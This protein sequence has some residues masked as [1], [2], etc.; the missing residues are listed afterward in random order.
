MAWFAK[1]AQP[2]DPSPGNLRML[3]LPDLSVLYWDPF[4]VATQSDSQDPITGPDDRCLPATCT[5]VTGAR[6]GAIQC[7]PGTP[8]NANIDRSP[9]LHQ[10]RSLRHRKRQVRGNEQRQRQDWGGVG[11]GGFRLLE[12]PRS[13]LFDQGTETCLCATNGPSAAISNRNSVGR[14]LPVGYA[15]WVL[16][17]SRRQEPYGGKHEVL[18][19]HRKG[20]GSIRV[21]CQAIT[22]VPGDARLFPPDLKRNGTP[23]RKVEMDA[24]IAGLWTLKTDIVG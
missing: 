2:S 22:S 1:G 18:T 16:I 21:G 10:T 3:R 20:H 23:V 24:A 13:R 9:P 17:R 4:R 6:F 7:S 5:S 11:V 19:G 14:I 8:A 12:P 15:S